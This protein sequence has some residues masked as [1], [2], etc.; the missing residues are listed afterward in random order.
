LEP[1]ENT[2]RDDAQNQCNMHFQ[3]YRVVT[4]D[5]FGADAVFAA[6]F[7]LSICEQHNS[8]N[9]GWVFVKFERLVNYGSEI[10]LLNFI[11]FY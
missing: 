1:T 8:K 9:Y 6:V 11:T 7:C 2:Y 3:T 5:T 10:R 4:S